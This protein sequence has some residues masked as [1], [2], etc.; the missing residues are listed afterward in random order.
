MSEATGLRWVD[1]EPGQAHI[2]ES[3]T[4]ARTVALSSFAEKIATSQP[5]S[6]A[7]IFGGDRLTSSQV[8]YA[9][10]K[11]RASC[12]LEDVRI[13]DLRHTFASLHVMAGTHPEVLRSLMGH[14]SITTTQRYMHVDR[15]QERKALDAVA[16]L[17]G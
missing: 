13:H 9:W 7:Y 11:I 5:R 2:S 12:Q 4:G 6:G 17:I 8:W 10:R 1:L 16:G 15:E 14:A 3:K